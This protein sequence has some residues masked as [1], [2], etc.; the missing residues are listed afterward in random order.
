[1]VVSRTMRRVQDSP[2]AKRR[3]SVL[4]AHVLAVLDM[5]L[6]SMEEVT[7]WPL[8]TE[9]R[10]P[11][12][13]RAKWARLFAK[14][15]SD[16]VYHKDNPKFWVLWIMFQ[17]GCVRRRVRAKRTRTTSCSSSSSGNRTRLGCGLS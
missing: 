6:P 13:A 10:I 8:L 4:G 1:M 12:N 5:E 7:A 3:A 11:A 15:C 9:P 16:A 2:E 14:L 17:H